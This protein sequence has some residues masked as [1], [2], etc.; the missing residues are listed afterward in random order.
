MDEIDNADAPLKINMQKLQGTW[1]AVCLVRHSK[2]DNTEA[3]CWHFRR[4]GHCSHCYAIMQ[5]LRLRSFDQPLPDPASAPADF[6]PVG[7][8]SGS[9]ND[10]ARG[11]KRAGRPK[12]K[13]PSVRLL[14]VQLPCTPAASASLDE[15]A[16]AEAGRK[17]VLPAQRA[18]KGPFGR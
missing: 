18:R 1:E 15:E 11:R 16:E 8:E 9:S 17:R 4:R 12:R 13:R 3:S 10:G 6:V 14:P 2:R 5:R 7:F